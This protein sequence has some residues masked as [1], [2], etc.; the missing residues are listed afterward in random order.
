M[1]ESTY[2]TKREPKM[3]S[4][5]ELRYFLREPANQEHITK[6]ITEANEAMRHYFPMMP[7]GVPQNYRDAILHEGVCL[8][9]FLVGGS[10]LTNPTTKERTQHVGGT[11]S[12]TPFVDG[13]PLVSRSTGR[14][15]KFESYEAGMAETQKL[16]AQ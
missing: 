16:I 15:L 3:L 4:V 13:A 14:T 8:I 10:W 2:T 9:P 6:V 5:Q 12:Y 7:E 11:L 1:T